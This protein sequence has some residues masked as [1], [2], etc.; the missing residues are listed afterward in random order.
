MKRFGKILTG[1]LLAGSAVAA[2]V[3]TTAPADARVAIGIGIG[4][5][6]YYGPAYYPPGPCYDYDYYYDGYCGYPTYSGAVFIGG[7]WVNGRHFYRWW[8]GAPWFWWHGHWHNWHGWRGAHFN[9][10]HGGGHWGGGHWGGGHHM[11]GGHWGGG[12]MGGGHWGGHGG[13]T[14]VGGHIGTHSGGGGHHHH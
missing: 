1:A 5:P 4:V 12:H 7:R 13:G 9:W 3:A 2:T 6:G 11:G 10:N 14:H 8:G